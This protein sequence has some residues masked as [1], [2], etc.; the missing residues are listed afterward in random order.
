MNLL[1]SIYV[2]QGNTMQA[3]HANPQN[4]STILFA[5]YGGDSILGS[6]RCLLDLLSHL[7]RKCFTPIVWCNSK[8]MANEVRHLGVLVIQSEFP[9]L[10]GWQPPRF[11]IGA[12]YRLVKQ[13]IK[14]VDVYGVSL[15]HSN[16]GAPNQWL[17]LV[18]RA[19]H[20]PLLTQLHS[21]YPLRERLSLGLHHVP[22]VV[23]VSQPII[24]QLLRDGMPAE[25]TCVIPN[26]IDTNR[27]ESQPRVNLRSM[28]NLNKDDFVIASVG[29]LIHRKGTDLI[30]D[31]MSRLISKGIPAQL[32]VI[33]EGPERQRL[34][35]QVQR[36][37][38]SNQI[39]L[40]GKQSNVVGLLSDGV[41]LFV[42][43]AREEAFGLVLAEAGLASL[44]V[45]APA[46][47]GIPDVITDGKNGVLVPGE[48]VSALARAIHKLFLSPQ[49]R[50]EMG[51]AG[52]RHVLEHFT[53][54]RNVRQFEQL[55]S[56]MLHDPAMRMHWHSHWQWRRTFKN[57][58]RQLL[59][60]ARN[61]FL[62]K[63]TA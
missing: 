38:L 48:N 13:G 28:L 58:S 33:G 23:G 62:R 17:K 63:V 45:V 4:R 29:S 35:Q 39:H 42:S 34:Q 27:L 41:D 51:I 50:Y 52:R 31:A 9:L 53:I 37:G 15:I 7:D 43:A 12:F 56:R 2:I 49:R 30:I 20:V 57:I 47:G 59:N 46:V 6:E 26:G 24:D 60:L 10:L 61:R 14:L 25:R 36:L 21:R 16:S 3:H 55:Y 19:S 18:A 5:H 8:T 54:Q 11:A 40:L 44:A 22:M 32:I 1:Q